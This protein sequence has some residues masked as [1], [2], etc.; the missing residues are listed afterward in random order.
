MFWEAVGVHE[1]DRDGF[2]A[3]GLGR[4]QIC[5]HRRDI[6]FL[7]DRAVGAHAFVNFGHTFIEHFGLDDVARENFRTCLIA[8]LERVTETLGDQ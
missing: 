8:D 5:A 2:D 7:F 3:V 6:W 1:H 4:D